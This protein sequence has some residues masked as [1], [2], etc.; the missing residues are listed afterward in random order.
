MKIKVIQYLISNDQKY[1]KLAKLAEKINHNYCKINGYDFKFEYKD[2]ESNLDFEA[3]TFYKILYI[4]ENLND[5]DYLVFID[6]DAAISNP[7]IK[8]E[9]L[10]DDK[11]E[12]FLS[13]GNDRL[14]QLITLQNLYNNL[15]KFLSENSGLLLT[16]YFHEFVD[17]FNL[18]HDLERASLGNIFFNEGFIIVKSTNQMK[19]FFS[20]CSQ[21]GKYFSNRI[22]SGLEADGAVICF[23]LQQKK[24]NQLYSF[25][26]DYAQGGFANSYEGKYDENKTFILHNYGKALNFEQKCQAL[27]NLLL[28]KWWKGIK[29]DNL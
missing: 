9:N 16:N 26:P 28:N 4:N 27:E 3:T 7:T 18:Y 11:H 19:E 17:K 20:L 15:V 6:A 2:N 13:R 8:I 14:Y 23:F 12:L 1:L 22:H 25:L 5:C 29:N 21:F 24:F 10:I